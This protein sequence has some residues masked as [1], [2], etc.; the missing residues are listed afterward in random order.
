MKEIWDYKGFKSCL[1]FMLLL[2]TNG[3]IG[4]N[5]FKRQ[6]PTEIAEKSTFKA[7]ADSAFLY[8][9]KNKLDTNYVILVN[10]QI[11]S[12]KDRLVVWDF[13][14]DSVLLKGLCSHGSCNG[15]TGPGYSYE[16]AIFSN[17]KGSYCS[18]LGK[19]KIGMRS[20][21][22]WGINV[23]YKLHGL[24]ASNSNAFKRIVVLHSY[25]GVPNS[26]VYPEHVMNSWG[27]PMVSN[28]LMTL[29]DAHLKNHK[30]TLLWIY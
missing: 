29:L 26:P 15:K 20:Y 18:S 11:H 28:E 22:S 13:K 3:L 16:K 24:Q 12:G 21:S 1:I 6:N 30:N 17:K 23:H 4:C 10:M 27:C 14:G 8:C 9:K 19:Y 2:A 5:D 25:D 7:K